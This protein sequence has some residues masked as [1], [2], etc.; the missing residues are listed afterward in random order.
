MA[1]YKRISVTEKPYLF[2]QRSSSMDPDV[3]GDT[4]GKAFDDV[5]RFMSEKQ[6]SPAGP[7]LSV[8]YT[9]DPDTLEFRAGFFVSEDDAKLA[10]GDVKAASTPAGN[11]LMLVHTGPYSK[12]R[13][14]YG[15]MMKYLD[16]QGLA[17]GV[18]TWEVYID[19]PHTTSEEELRTEIFMALP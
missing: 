10:S 16:E 11:A 5:L 12:L 7:A 4:M 17:P 1:E 3:V 13:D 15:E 18:P 9:Y 14:T 6:I 19:D 2:V 8:Y